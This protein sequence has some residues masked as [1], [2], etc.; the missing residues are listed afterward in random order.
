M[1]LDRRILLQ[2]RIVHSQN[3][4]PSFYAEC[5]GTNNKR[6]LFCMESIKR[7][8]YEYNII[9]GMLHWS[10]TAEGSDVWIDRCE[11]LYKYLKE[12]EQ[13]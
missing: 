3:Y 5:T 4:Y 8:E 6:Y 2:V 7:G 11:K 10:K 9:D 12:L 13:L 1:D